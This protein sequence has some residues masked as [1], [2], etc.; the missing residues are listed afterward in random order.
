MGTAKTN[1]KADAT[2]DE[3]VRKKLHALFAATETVMLLSTEGNRI[4]GRPMGLIRVD[5][6][7]TMYFTTDINSEK[8]GEISVRPEVS[9]AFQGRGGCS[10]I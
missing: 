9:I 10:A 8:L 2:H 3:D 6:D 4:H 1:P 5:A 7:E